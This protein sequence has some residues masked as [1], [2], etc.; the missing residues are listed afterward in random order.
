MSKLLWERDF[1]QNCSKCD[2]PHTTVREDYHHLP[3]QSFHFSHLISRVKKNK[4]FE[5]VCGSNIFACCPF[6]G[7]LPLEK[8]EKEK[9]LP[10]QKGRERAPDLECL[11]AGLQKGA[12]EEANLVVFH[13]GGQLLGLSVLPVLRL[14]LNALSVSAPC[15]RTTTVAAVPTGFAESQL[16]LS[17]KK[18]LSQTKLS[19]AML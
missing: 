16:G 4:V 10:S 18:G 3:P 7:E 11:Q 8:K 13:V 6:P 12:R 9:K 14:K 19:P 15:E 1:R 2:P 5:S 17:E